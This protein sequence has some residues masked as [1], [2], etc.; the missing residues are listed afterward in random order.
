MGKTKDEKEFEKRVKELA[1]YI[2][3]VEDAVVFL[4]ELPEVLPALEIESEGLDW[5]SVYKRLSVILEDLSSFLI[6]S[7]VHS[8]GAAAGLREKVKFNM[9]LLSSLFDDIRTRRTKK[10]WLEWLRRKRLKI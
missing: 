4:T 3:K 2:E 6:V 8:R 10:S 7:R 1:S 9:K 5:N